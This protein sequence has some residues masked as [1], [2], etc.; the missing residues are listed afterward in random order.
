MPALHGGLWKGTDSTE[1]F[2]AG[3][4]DE[5]G[6]SGLFAIHEDAD[7]ID[8]GGDPGHYDE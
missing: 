8:F 3:P 6:N 1:L 4:A 2:V 7:A 5:I